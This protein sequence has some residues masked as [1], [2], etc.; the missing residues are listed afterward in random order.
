[1]PYQP[2]SKETIY[3]DVEG[4]VKN[5]SPALTNFHPQTPNYILLNDG[6]AE[7][8]S[9]YEQAL[10][11][12]QLS[13]WVDYA[14]GPFVEEDLLDLGID[15]D[16]VNI[17]FIN[18]LLYDRDLDQIG[19]EQGVLRDPGTEATG[20]VLITL[21][22]TGGVVE[23]NTEFAT[24]PQDDGTYLSYFTTQRVEAEQNSEI[25]YA[26]I[27]AEGVGTDYNV[28]TGQVTYI[29]EGQSSSATNVTNP[30]AIDGG[31]GP[32]DND[33]YRTRI[34]E[35]T[36]RQSNGGTKNSIRGEIL[37]QTDGIGDG[38]ILVDEI[39]PSDSNSTK[40]YP[41]VDVI[42]DYSSS[43]ES[44]VLTAIADKKPVGVEHN[45]LQP[46]YVTLDVTGTLVGTDIDITRVEN[47]VVNY[48]EELAIGDDVR[49][50]HIIH[51]TMHADSDIEHIDSLSITAN[52]TSVS[53]DYIAS[54]R[55]SIDPNTINLTVA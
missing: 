55:E 23:G 39:Q 38:D 36:S 44:T 9:E 37:E 41:Y 50:D 4:N 14:G 43:Q 27:E 51:D 26:P 12:I 10:L 8:F 18:S 22:I 46:T 29:P 3:S 13:G 52:G 6:Y 48:L 21:D 20:E 24:Q 54:D 31:E 34:K 45:L 15:P 5:Q 40:S 33:P 42:V 35:S 2:D 25:V 28:G 16:A 49:R 7:Q 17:D 53:N 1:M 30:N 47:T 11:A 32:E 19:K